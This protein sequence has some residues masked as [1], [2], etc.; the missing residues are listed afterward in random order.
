VP[1]PV[2]MMG[3]TEAKDIG[4]IAVNDT[5]VYWSD[6]TTGSVFVC[7]VAACGSSSPAAVMTG[8][9]AGR[10][11]RIALAD[12]TLYAADGAH[13]RIAICPI[14][15]GCGGNP[16][17]MMQSDPGALWV[18][19]F[20]TSF[21]WLDDGNT[22]QE[23]S[24]YSCALAGCNPPNAIAS[25]GGYVW[26]DMGFAVDDAYAYWTDGY[27]VVR[28]PHGGCGTNPT[29]LQTSGAVTFTGIA[30]DAHQLYWLAGGSLVA[31]PVPNCS[32]DAKT[33]AP[34]SN[35]VAVVSDGAHVYFTD[36]GMGSTDGRVLE[37]DAAGCNMTPTVMASGQPSPIDLA[38]AGPYLYWATAWPSSGGSIMR[39]QR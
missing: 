10:K 38:I 29:V 14:P 6:T 30:V 31:C 16:Y 2:V 21:Y 24:I 12:G 25:Q 33:L 27:R 36:S 22:A 9:G 35:G 20:G 11:N 3:T 7:P 32:N 23:A 39:V 13:N 5:N 19:V 26:G 8:L 1:E 28:C 18:R 17:T 15:G 4:S 37:C 34:G